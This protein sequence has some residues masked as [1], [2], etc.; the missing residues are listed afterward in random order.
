MLT[1][2]GDMLHGAMPVIGGSIT[3]DATQSPRTR[4]TVDLPTQMVPGPID[5]DMIPVCQRLRLEYSIEHYGQWVVVAD[6]DVIRSTVTRPASIWSVEAV[7]RAARVG[8]DDTSRGA[9]AP[10]TTGTIGAA[11]T[12]I[13]RRTFPQTSFLITGPALTQTVPPD[14]KTFGDTWDLARRMAQL[15]GS[16]LFFRA[17]DRVCVVRPLPDVGAPVDALTVGDLG[18]VTG[19]TLDHQAGYNTVA[20]R[21]LSADG[22]DVLRTGLWV[23][24][25]TDSPVAVQRLGSHVVL[26]ED[27]EVDTAPSQADADAA[28]LALGRR[29]AGKSRSPSIRHVSRPW[30]EPGDT[31]DVTYAGGPTEA[32][33]VDA[34]EIPLDGSNIQTTVLRTH[35][36]KMGVPV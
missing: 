5:Q 20:M 15:A 24:R 36:Y 18:T 2:T 30:L 19:Y 11:I 31:V 8:L 26:V 12:Y 27:K 28:A 34:V 4:V 14:S 21:Y 10:Q 1:A 3:K 25:R 13:V 22:G 6:L 7:D 35:A 29:A 16:E 9:W 32:Q 23:D 33:V 17:H